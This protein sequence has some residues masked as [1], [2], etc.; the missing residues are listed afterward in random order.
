MEWHVTKMIVTFFVTFLLK[1]ILAYI[2][3]YKWFI[4]S[5]ALSTIFVTK[6]TLVMRKTSHWL[7]KKHRISTVIFFLISLFAFLSKITLAYMISFK[8]F[9]SSE[10]LSTIFMAKFTLVTEKHH[11]DFMIKTLNFF[12]YCFKTPLLCM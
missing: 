12:M 6:F 3:F 5:E 8:Q 4:R 1:N 11:T 10:V 7:C 2:I 9:I